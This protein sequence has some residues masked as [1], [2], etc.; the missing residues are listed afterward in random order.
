MRQKGRACSENKSRECPVS[1]CAVNWVSDGKCLAII[2]KK[3]FSSYHKA[4]LCLFYGKS[5]LACLDFRNVRY[6][7]LSSRAFKNSPAVQA[8]RVKEQ[9]ALFHRNITA[10]INCCCWL[11]CCRGNFPIS[12]IGVY[13]KI[14][15]FSGKN[16]TK[17]FSNIR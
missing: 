15:V 2:Q 4:V 9:I 3:V 13:E 1:S 16:F 14:L 11:Y 17:P 8:R 5:I 10:N 7:R 12:R 6:V